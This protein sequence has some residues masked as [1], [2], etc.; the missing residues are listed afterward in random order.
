MMRKA[1]LYVREDPA[2]LNNVI[3]S[4]DSLYGM[5]SDM[6]MYIALKKELEIL[7]IDISTQDLH[8]VSDSEIVIVLNETG[9]FRT[10][11]K[12]PGQKLYL[13]LSEPPVYNFDDWK[14]ENHVVFDKVFSYDDRLADNVKYFHYNYSIDFD[15]LDKPLPVSRKEFSEKKVCVLMA[16]TFSFLPHKKEMLS[17][18]YERYS[19]VRWFNLH[20]PEHLDFFSR[21]AIQKKFE[22]FRGASYLQRFAPSLRKK[23]ASYL[24]KKNCAKVFKGSVPADKKVETMKKYKFYLSYENTYGINGLISEKIFDCFAAACIPIYKG[25]PDIGHYVPANCFINK[26]DFKSYSELHEFLVNMTFET[27]SEYINNIIKFMNSEKIQ[28][29]K[30]STFTKTITSQLA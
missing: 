12:K 28:P 5:K 23:I 10:Y 13:I 6:Y 8:P 27:Y 7:N 14:K 3:F 25:A 18:L 20:F 19:A 17:L 9:F 16:G 24:F 15:S 1:T 4:G 29:F 2:L 22:E 11:K 26:D 30:V 21:A